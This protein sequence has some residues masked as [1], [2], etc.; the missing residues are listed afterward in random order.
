MYRDCN[1]VR[2]AFPSQLVDR[3]LRQD[4][5]CAR[6]GAKVEHSA[7]GQDLVFNRTTQ[8][9]VDEVLEMFVSRYDACRNRVVLNGKPPQRTEEL[10]RVGWACRNGSTRPS[11]TT[12]T[13]KRT[14]RRLVTCPTSAGREEAIS[15]PTNSDVLW[16]M[17]NA[18]ITFRVQDIRRIA[19]RP[20]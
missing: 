2:G 19:A 18:L 4:E 12:S 6:T 5:S 14:G 16:L 3:P 17:T 20:I 11:R 15:P 10:D 8:N 13:P 9:D 7:S 1:S